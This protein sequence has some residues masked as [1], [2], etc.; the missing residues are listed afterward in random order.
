VYE[1]FLTWSNGARPDRGLPMAAARAGNRPV[2]IGR[3]FTKTK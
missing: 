2:K 1:P 3:F